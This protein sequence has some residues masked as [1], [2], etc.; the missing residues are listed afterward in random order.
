MEKDFIFSRVT[1][2]ITPKL[3]IPIQNQDNNSSLELMAENGEQTGTRESEGL[4][5]YQCE[6]SA[7]PG[8]SAG[9]LGHKPGDQENQK[10]SAN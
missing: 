7:R 9:I 5:G 3:F 8:R 2:L 6:A 1:V 4:S 10:R